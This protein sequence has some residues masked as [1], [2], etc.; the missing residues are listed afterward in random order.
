MKLLDF[1]KPNSEF[2]TVFLECFACTVIRA[3]LIL[4]PYAYKEL[5]GSIFS[6]Y[7]YT[8]LSYGAVTSKC[9]ITETSN[10]VGD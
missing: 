10:T 9:G 5:P 6:I 3:E 2:Y 7:I 8:D 4:G 1:E